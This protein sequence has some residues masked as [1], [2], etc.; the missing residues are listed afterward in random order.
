MH[1]LISRTE[2]SSDRF[3]ISFKQK[4]S[5]LSFSN[6]LIM[7]EKDRHLYDLTS[8]CVSDSLRYRW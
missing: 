5:P 6:E 7:H 1:I 2:K 8:G 4:I 3:V